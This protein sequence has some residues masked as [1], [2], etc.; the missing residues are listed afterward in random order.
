MAEEGEVVV[1]G[2]AAAGSFFSW[3][4]SVFSIVAGSST[5]VGEMLI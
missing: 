5:E 2:A 3:P 1:V 4:S